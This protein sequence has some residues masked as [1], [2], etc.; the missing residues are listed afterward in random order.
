[1]GPKAKILISVVLIFIVGLAVW[2]LTSPRSIPAIGT[3]YTEPGPFSRDGSWIQL[4][5]TSP[6]LLFLGFSIANITYPRTALSTTYSV[7]IS[8]LNETI[9][10]PY[11]KSFTVRVTGLT[12]QDNYDGK[13]SGYDTTGLLP[14]A[15]QVTSLFYFATSADHALRF[16]VSYDVY[17]LLVIGSVI[18]HSETRSFNITQNV[19]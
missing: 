13:Y 6:G 14:D 4:E 16:T 9:T 8:K 3:K 11:T 17:S 1:M 19:T 12:I 15:V 18:D 2:Q 5:K 7:V 10:G